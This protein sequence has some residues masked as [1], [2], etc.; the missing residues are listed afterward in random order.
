MRENIKGVI[1][2]VQLGS[3]N[4]ESLSEGIK[5][6]KP[7]ILVKIIDAYKMDQAMIFCRTKVDCD[8]LEH[9]L[10]DIAT[11][12]KGKAIKSKNVCSKG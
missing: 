1:D 8:N 12:R 6:L 2:K 9:Y 10:S 4:A 3:E 11:V 5:M 7:S